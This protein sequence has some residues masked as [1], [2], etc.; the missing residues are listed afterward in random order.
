MVDITPKEDVVRIARARGRIWLHRETIKRILDGEVEKGDV[1]EATKLVVMSAV[2]R[3]SYLLPFC[4]PI[5]ITHVDT[6][7]S[8]GENYVDVEVCVKAYAKTGV[9]MEA[10]L[11]VS[12]G[13]LNIWDMVK[14]YEKD[15]LGQYPNTKI[16]DI[17]VVEKKKGFIDYGRP[18][19]T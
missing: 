11:G 6:S 4:H 2:K 5:G 19:I 8:V 18:K 13:L 1:L 16:T 17:V 14:K 7:I 3:T 12:I 15:H 9:E 10:L